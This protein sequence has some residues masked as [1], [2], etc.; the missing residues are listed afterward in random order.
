MQARRPIHVAD[1]ST[2]FMGLQFDDPA[3]NRP[4]STGPGESRRMLVR[5]LAKET[6]LFTME[7]VEARRGAARLS[8]CA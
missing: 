2:A 8:V 5:G 3:Y 7:R 4:V 6:F 1:R